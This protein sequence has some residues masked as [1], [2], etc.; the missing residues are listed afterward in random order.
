MMGPSIPWSSYSNTRQYSGGWWRWACHGQ[1]V[2]DG[3]EGRALPG[4]PVA[5]QAAPEVHFVLEGPL[6]VLPR[7]VRI[8]GT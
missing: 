6:R 3:Y 2:H 7:Q 4:W 8:P 5:L 1:L